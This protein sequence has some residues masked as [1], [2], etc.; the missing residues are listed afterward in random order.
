VDGLPGSFRRKHFRCQGRALLKTLEKQPKDVKKNAA[1]VRDTFILSGGL[2]S[3]SAEQTR[4][5][6]NL[7]LTAEQM[8]MTFVTAQKPTA[9]KKPRV[10]Q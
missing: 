4:N 7:T 1:L 8:V 6:T 5:F 9:S 2:T 3:L 10:V